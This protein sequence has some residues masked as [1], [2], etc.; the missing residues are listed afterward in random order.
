M[1]I[2]LCMG[3]FVM[4]CF[5]DIVTWVAFFVLSVYA[6]SCELQIKLIGLDATLS[7]VVYCC[8]GYTAY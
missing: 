5:N 1:H 2:L 8:F 7:V 4:L 6:L 3:V